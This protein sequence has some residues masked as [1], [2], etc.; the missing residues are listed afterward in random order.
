MIVP[1]ER[2]AGVLLMAFE[3]VH[4]ILTTKSISN[5]PGHSALVVDVAL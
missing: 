2:K 1:H 3:Y 4:T 5:V